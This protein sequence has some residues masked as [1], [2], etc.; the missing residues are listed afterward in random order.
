MCA[1]HDKT[2]QHK[3]NQ[4][5]CHASQKERTGPPIPSGGVT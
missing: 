4:I 2:T 5:K 3:A 1:I